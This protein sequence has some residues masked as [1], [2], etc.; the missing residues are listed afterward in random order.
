MAANEN[1]VDDSVEWI[2]RTNE[3]LGE[4][5]NGYQLTAAIQSLV[6]TNN[7]ITAI[8]N[9]EP[10]VA[11][12]EL[13]LQRNTVKTLDG[14]DT[15]RE[16]VHLDLYM[17][18]VEHISSD[19]F[20]NN[21]KLQKLDLSFNALRSLD[22]FPCENLPA[23]EELF[24]IGNKVKQIPHFHSLPNLTMLELGDNR[25]R[26]IEN[27]SMLTNLRELWLGRNKIT[28]IQNLEALTKLRRLGMQSNRIECIEGLDHLVHLEELYLSHNGITS[29]DGIQNLRSLK[30]LDLGSNYIVHVQHVDALPCLNELWICG[31]QLESLEEFSILSNSTELETVYLE[32]NPLASD[33]EYK[34]K[35]LAILPDTLEQLDASLVEDIRTSLSRSAEV[36]D[37][38]TGDSSMAIPVEVNVRLVTNDPVGLQSEEAAPQQEGTSPNGTEQHEAAENKPSKEVIVQE[39]PMEDETEI[40]D[41]CKNHDP[42]VQEVSSEKESLQTDAD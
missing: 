37:I 42:L 40:A 8:R 5:G 24:L 26:L 12:R 27:L 17:N 1:G 36:E 10:C 18:R 41:G 29:M 2:D 25:L 34:R 20:R 31:N 15:L 30:V 11:L 4:I 28:K 13:V 7:R 16:L 23:L 38:C 39:T 3:P 33:A 32:R 6:L 14:L 21:P 35:A 19:C 9:L 22:G